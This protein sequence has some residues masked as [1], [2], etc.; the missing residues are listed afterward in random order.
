MVININGLPPSQLKGTAD[1]NKNQASSSN[2]AGSANATP[3]A[4]SDSVLITDMA[5]QLSNIEKSL[6][7]LPVVNMQL[8]DGV[9]QSLDDG[10]FEVDPMQVA[11]KIIELE[12]KYN[13][14]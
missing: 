5:S 10:T 12:S 1:S 6:A 14:L 4:S 13:N 2:K 8:V 11:E 7:S 9:K 3:A